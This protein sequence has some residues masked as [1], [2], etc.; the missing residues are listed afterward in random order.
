LVKYWLIFGSKSEGERRKTRFFVT[1]ASSQDSFRA[2]DAIPEP[3][4][5]KRT[6]G[7]PGVMGAGSGASSARG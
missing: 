1:P 5:Q 2:L 6:R 3:S 7:V 4:G